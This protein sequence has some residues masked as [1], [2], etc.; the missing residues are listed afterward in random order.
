MDD[1]RQQI[2]TTYQRLLEAWNR[3][4]A[5]AFGALF[6]ESG[7]AVGFDGSQMNGQAEI[8]ATLRAIFADHRTASYVAKIREVRPLGPGVTLLRAVV[9]MIPPGAT[10]LNPAVNAVQSLVTVTEAGRTRIA[11]LHNTPAAFHGRPQMVEQLTAEL[12]EVVRQG[13]LIAG[14]A[15]EAQPTGSGHDTERGGA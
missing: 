4:D 5:D 1:E 14:I 9:G 15:R 10:E 11:L 2:V 12:S 8:Q 6:T 7:T 13:Q 3:R